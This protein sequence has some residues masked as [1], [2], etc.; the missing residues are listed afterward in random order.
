MGEPID[1]RQERRRAPARSV[2]ALRHFGLLTDRGDWVIE[3]RVLACAYPRREGTLRALAGRG[4]GTLVNLHRRPH[5][6][7]RLQRHGLTEIH[8][9]V[10]DFAAPTPE[11]LRAGV[12]AVDQALAGGGRVAVHCGAGLGRTGTLLACCLVG[13][14]LDPE[15]AIGRVRAARPGAI[16]TAAQVA[17]VHAFT[18]SS[19]G[20]STE[21][22]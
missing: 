13:C 19:N 14:G 12:A 2:A 7:A 8:L 20:A 11:Q 22:S 1:T 17:A 10:R 18:R 5:D 16:E 21:G 9:P 15:A 3:E 4:V 6:A